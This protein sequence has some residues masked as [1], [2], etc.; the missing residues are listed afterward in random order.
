MQSLIYLTTP[1]IVL[2]TALLSRAMDFRAQAK[3]NML[4][5]LASAATALGGALGGLGVWTLVIILG[6]LIPYLDG[7]H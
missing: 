3:V 5:S 1:F 4:A 2:P 7:M 6:R